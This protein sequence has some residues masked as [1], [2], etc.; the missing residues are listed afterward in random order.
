MAYTVKGQF[1]NN[2]EQISKYAEMVSHI[3]KFKDKKGNFVDNDISLNIDPNDNDMYFA[4][5]YAILG[6]TMMD[7]RLKLIGDSTNNLYLEENLKMLSRE[8]FP[9]TGYI[10]RII[11]TNNNY[12]KSFSHPELDKNNPWVINKNKDNVM[13]AEFGVQLEYNK[14]IELI[15]KNMIWINRAT[16]ELNLIRRHIVESKCNDAKKTYIY[17]KKFEK[18][19]ENILKDGSDYDGQ[20]LVTEFLDKYPSYIFGDYNKE[21]IIEDASYKKVEEIK[22]QEMLE[23]TMEEVFKYLSLST[24][25]TTLYQMKIRF[26]EL[27]IMEIGELKKS[28]KMNGIRVCK[29]SDQDYKS[30]S[31]STVLQIV[32][33]GYN[34]PFTVHANEKHL[35]DLAIKYN[36]KYEDKNLDNPGLSYC[37][38]KYNNKQI[39]QINKLSKANITNTRISRCVEYANERCMSSNNYER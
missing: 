26:V 32:L 2:P 36:V 21:E 1:Y 28:R 9:V 10:D 31:Y 5:N 16:K 11:D 29:T 34:C 24:T 15:A 23:M 35:T 39:E 8:L 12:Y 27:A 14:R 6:Q 19:V 3:H 30:N 38:Y 13:D 7:T 22:N 20:T 18:V 17:G 25:E 33:P 37:T 4:Y